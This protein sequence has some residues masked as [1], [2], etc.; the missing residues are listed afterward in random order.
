[1][2]RTKGKVEIIVDF[3]DGLCFVG[4]AYLTGVEEGGSLSFV[5]SGPLLQSETKDH[6]KAHKVDVCEVNWSREI[7]VLPPDDSSWQKLSIGRIS[8]SG[9]IKSRKD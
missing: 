3:G 1:M 7:D 6:E 5:G 4:D 8:Y 9:T 2:R